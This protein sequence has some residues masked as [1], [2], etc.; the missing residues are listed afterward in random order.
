MHYTS[1]PS[2]SGREGRVCPKQNE[3]YFLPKPLGYQVQKQD[4]SVTT[5]RGVS[6]TDILQA[7]AETAQGN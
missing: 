6:S 7:Y 3:E 1:L 4:L 5:S 2:S